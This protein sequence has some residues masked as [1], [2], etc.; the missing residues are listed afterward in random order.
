M[1][2]AWSIVLYSSSGDSIIGCGDIFIYPLYETPSIS[3]LMVTIDKMF[4]IVFQMAVEQ[5]A[6]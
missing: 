1:I 4:E 6:C 5:N 3:A 2:F